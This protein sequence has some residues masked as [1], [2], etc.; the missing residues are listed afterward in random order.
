MGPRD[1]L[2]I[3]SVTS[4]LVGGAVGALSARAALRRHYAEIAEAEIADAREYYKAFKKED[5]FATP[6]GMSD[7]LGLDVSEPKSGIDSEKAKAA[8][9]ALTSYQPTPVT[10]EPSRG[11]VTIEEAGEGATEINVF[12]NNKALNPNDFDYDVE[13]SKRNPQFPYVITEDEFNAGEMGFEQAS[14]TYYEGDDI[15]AGSDDKPI[16]AVEEVVGEDHLHMFGRGSSDPNTVHVR[17]ENIS[18]DFEITR[19][20][21]SFSTAVGGFIRHMDDRHHGARRFRVGDDE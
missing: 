13:V 7:A 6:Q 14:I 9:L 12:V 1:K 2:I 5:E 3:V 11:G 20:N 21:G 8:L 15:L 10:E 4:G 19:D 18:V 16:D 17:N